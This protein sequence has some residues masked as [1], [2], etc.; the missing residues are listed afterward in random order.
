VPG[1]QNQPLAGM[2]TNITPEPRKHPAKFSAGFID[3]FRALLTQHLYTPW[4]YPEPLI[5]DPFAGVGT[6]HQLRP[7]FTTYG[8]EIEPEWANERVHHL[9]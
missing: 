8:Y 5:F 9:W 2:G 6:I 3:V 1:F 7:E 4:K